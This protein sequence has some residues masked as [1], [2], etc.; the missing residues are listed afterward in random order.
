[1]RAEK[2]LLLDEV[3]EKIQGSK[4]FIVTQY[5]K[6]DAQAAREFRDVVANAKGEFEVVRKRVF[7]K[8]AEAVGIK[9][10]ASSF[11]GHIGV[12]FANEDATGLSKV[13]L[14]YG[15]KN[16]K[17]VLVVGGLIDGTLFSGEEVQAIARLPG[18]NELRSEFLGLLEAPMGQT[19]SL[20]QNLLTSLLYCLE[21]KSKKE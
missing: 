15:E 8:A 12:I 13:A 19:V 21:E 1:M 11:K 9:L 7:V 20:L 16:D 14:E 5:Q 3:K 2:Q 18:L 4:G 6:L 10:D 17:S